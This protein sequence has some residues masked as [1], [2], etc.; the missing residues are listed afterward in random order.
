MMFK[1]FIE[2]QFPVSKISAESYKERKAGP[3][4]TLTPLGR[5]WG[6]K[7]TI[8]VRAAILGLLFPATVDPKKDREIFLKILTMDNEGVLRR[9]SKNLTSAELFENASDEEKTTWFDELDSQKPKLKRGK[10]DQEKSSFQK[11]VFQRL[12]YDK[13]LT[14]CDR[15]EQ[16]DGPS[17]LE[18]AEINSHLK[19]NAHSISDLIQEL[20]RNQFGHTPRIGDSFCGGGSIPFEAARIGCEVYASDL[21]PVA[22]LLSWASLNLVGGG[23][24]LATDIKKAQQNVFDIVDRKIKQLGIEHNEKGWRADAYLYCAEVRCPE[25]GWMVPLAPSW[26][27]GEK[28]KCIAELIPDHLNKRYD[29]LIR[30]G[31]SDAEMAKA[32]ASATIKNSRLVHP[33]AEHGT[34]ISTLRGDRRTSEGTISGLRM[35]ENSDVIPRPDDVF[36]ERLYCIR[37]VEQNSE[38]GGVQ[39]Q[40]H[41]SA[42]TEADLQKEMQTIEL[43]KEQ[44]ERWQQNGIIP[45]RRIES[46]YNTDQPTRERGWSFWHHLFNPRQLLLLGY[47]SETITEEIKEPRLSIACFL[48]LGKTINYNSRLSAWDPTPS[49][50]MVLSVFTNLALNTLFNYGCRSLQAVGT[51]WFFDLKSYEIHSKFVVEP[52]DAREI[53]SVQDFWITDP[54]YADAVNY[55]ELAEFFLAWYEPVFRTQFKTWYVDSKKALA[56]KGT[57]LDFKESMVACYKSLAQNM[58]SNGAQIVMF[59]HQDASVW[60]DLTLILW[61]SGLRVTAAWCIGTET[62]NALK[63]GNYVQGTVLLILRKQMSTEVA[64]L[65][66]L[67]PRVEAEV[68]SQLEEMLKL[69]DQNSPNFGDADFQ[70]AAYA[71]ALRVLTQYKSIEDIDI[72][73]ELKKVRISSD[74]SPIELIIDNAVKVAC[75]FLVPKGFD[76]QTWKAL[77]PEEK[78]YLKGLEVESHGEN[79]AGVYQELARGFGVREYKPLLFSEKANHARLR[80]AFEFGTKLLDG[81]GFGASGVRNILFAGHQAISTDDI[82][83]GKNW[84]KTEFK[85]YWNERRVL[86]QICNFISDTTGQMAHW[87]RD[88]KVLKLL[89]GALENDH[90]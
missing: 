63:E 17:A 90:A 3:T 29:I 67:F 59:T 5:W 7:P 60:A 42:P 22:S 46:G 74:R 16:I 14:F 23:E 2:T 84:L 73:S 70:L 75:D 20:G 77:R 71:A 79:R 88:S 10:S 34:S 32:K 21:N 45:S 15:P 54:P 80:T 76:T 55:H 58:T 56:V 89:A 8:L 19:T 48:S 40:R 85:N 61:A 65:D 82:Q 24:K 6:R 50:E 26:V 47:L 43:L 87:S 64:F 44:F 86:V 9:R 35:W 1:S 30:S 83:V 38:N 39:G 53:K 81:E 13:K 27:I 41:Y 18:W 25:T 66:E 36:Q 37:W 4:Q 49:K 78:L 57:Q 28:T 31:V 69:E 12:P 11:A 72:H 33:L 68:K 62:S 51:G 52:K